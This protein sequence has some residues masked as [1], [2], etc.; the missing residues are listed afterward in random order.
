M[1]NGLA[2]FEA[3]RDPG[4]PPPPRTKVLLIQGCLGSCPGSGRMS[5]ASAPRL[6]R[7]TPSSS[8]C[9]IAQDHGKD[10]QDESSH[11]HHPCMGDG[12]GLVRFEAGDGGDHGDDEG[13]TQEREPV[14]GAIVATAVPGRANREEARSLEWREWHA[15][16]VLGGVE[17]HT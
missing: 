11:T 1:A 9:Q 16:R 5:S 14:H 3:A 17:V 8:K 10:E 4:A 2:R 13:E 12:S 15:S 6:R 7:S